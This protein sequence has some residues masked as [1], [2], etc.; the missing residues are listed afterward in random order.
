MS[1][2][3]FYALSFVISQFVDF[4]NLLM[5]SS[6]ISCCSLLL[7]TSQICSV[8]CLHYNRHCIRLL[9]YF[10][11]IQSTYFVD[12]KS[13]IGTIPCKHI[14]ATSPMLPQWAVLPCF[15]KH[16]SC[17]YE[18]PVHSVCNA[19]IYSHLSPSKA[20]ISPSF[21]SDCARSPL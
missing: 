20:I 21:A 11:F 19:I 3:I 13:I 16:C 14:Q 6:C 18:P 15:P 5:V 8:H 17:R 12:S 10:N 7:P 2:H 4:S 1:E 9:F